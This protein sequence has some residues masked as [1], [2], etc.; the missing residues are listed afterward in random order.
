MFN[1]SALCEHHTLLLVLFLLDVHLPPGVMLG[2][3]SN[4]GDRSIAV[5]AD[6]P[7]HSAKSWNASSVPYLNPLGLGLS[8]A[9]D[10][11]TKLGQT[12]GV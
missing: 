8:W 4:L 6:L 9:K 11:V 3:A 5:R 1:L 10:G 7:C 2:I 12:R